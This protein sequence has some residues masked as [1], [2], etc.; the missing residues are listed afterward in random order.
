MQGFRSL[1]LENQPK[2]SPFGGLGTLMARENK[3]GTLAKI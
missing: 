1:A 3:R 2:E